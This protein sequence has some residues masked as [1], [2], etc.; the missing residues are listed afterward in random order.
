[1]NVSAHE[2]GLGGLDS[3]ADVDALCLFVGEDDRP[4]PGTAGYVDWRLCGALSRVLQSG[5]FVGAQDDSLLLP[6]DGRF[7]APRVFVMGLGQRRGLDPSSLGE[8]LASAGQVLTRARVQAVALEVPGQGT[9]DD[10]VRLSALQER[11]LPAFHGKKVAVLAD[12]DLA[13][14]L[15][16]RKG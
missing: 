7:A 2:L 6:T 5:F 1:V 12:K 15:S 14:R 11:F 8:A 13:R 9:L 16:G 10:S 3:L 4:L